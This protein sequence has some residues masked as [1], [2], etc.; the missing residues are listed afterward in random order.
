MSFIKRTKFFDSLDELAVKIDIKK[1]ALGAT[2][3][4]WQEQVVGVIWAALGV[5]ENGSF[6]YLVECQID[7]NLVARAYDEI[8][9]EKVGNLFR[10]A[11]ALLAPVARDPEWKNRLSFMEQHEQEF[12]DL[13]TKVLGFTVEMEK[14]LF[15]YVER[16]F[17][18]FSRLPPIITPTTPP[19]SSSP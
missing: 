3:L 6:Q 2:S 4:C 14:R 13:A 9:L 7:I 11:E 10:Q 18:I 16:N 8:G 5:L 12:D 17:Q 1:E 19:T 15:E